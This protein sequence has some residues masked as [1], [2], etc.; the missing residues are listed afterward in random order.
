MDAKQQVIV[1]A[2]N[3]VMNH[4]EVLS[5]DKLR[6]LNDVVASQLRVL[7]D[8]RRREVVATLKAGD[9]VTF[10]K[11]HRQVYVKVTSFNPKTMNGVE[12]NRDG[13][14]TIGVRRWKMAPTAVRKVEVTK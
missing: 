11:K 1:D 7:I 3:M 5:Y 14:P 9:I 4:V 2:A 10:V 8:Q 13:S 12:V 6:E